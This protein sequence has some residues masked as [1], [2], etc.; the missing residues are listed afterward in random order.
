MK[1]RGVFIVACILLCASPVFAA[2]VFPDLAMTGQLTSAHRQYL[3][4][5]ANDFSLSDISAE[6]VLIEVYSMY[7]PICQRDA[8]LVNT[9]YATLAEKKL[10]SRVKM[11]GIGAGN[12][13]YEV[14]F[15][16]KKFSVS[17]PLVPDVQ[18]VHH[19]AVGEVGTPSFYLV[20]LRQG[21]RL[22]FFQEGEL[23]ETDGVLKAIMEAL[24]Q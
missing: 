23:K 6:L 20:D 4:V 13:A 2:A 24:E 18:Y 15:Y 1:K 12:S 19:K 5:A 16:R 7:C 11:L 14:E 10:D 8:P 17:F 3:G 21:R 22:L 9:L